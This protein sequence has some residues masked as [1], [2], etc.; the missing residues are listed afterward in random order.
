MSDRRFETK[1]RFNIIGMRF[2]RLLIVGP[3]IRS[4]NGRFR[5]LCL[6]DCGHTINA[7]LNNLTAGRTRSCGCYNQEVNEEKIRR[8]NDNR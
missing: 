3:G 2:G 7:R 6:C 5:W 4:Y 8:L 1:K